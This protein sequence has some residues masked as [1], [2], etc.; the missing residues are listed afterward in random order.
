M[1]Q[2]ITRHVPAAIRP[3][4]APLVAQ[5]RRSDHRARAA[6]PGLAQRQ[7]RQP[8]ARYHPT[9]RSDPVHRHGRHHRRCQALR[10]RPTALGLDRYRAER[11]FHRRPPA[12]GWHHQDRRPLSA[13]IAGGRRQR[14]D[15]PGPRPIPRSPRGSLGSWSACRRR[16]RPS[17][18]PTRWRAS[19]GPCWF[20]APRIG[21]RSS[22][23]RPRRRHE[24]GP[25]L[26]PAWRRA[27]RPVDPGRDGETAAGSNEETAIKPKSG[28]WGVAGAGNLAETEGYDGGNQGASGS[29]GG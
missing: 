6:D 18:W 1:G 2:V 10:Q 28:G 26:G 25:D 17:R 27:R 22:P 9:I 11:G 16:R 3:I 24:R 7:C 23:H 20:T 21:R 19:P 5:R 15:P 12:T 8:V 13:V 29:P 4:L 14:P